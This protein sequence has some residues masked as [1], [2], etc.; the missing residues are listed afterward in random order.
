MVAPLVARESTYDGEWAELV[1]RSAITLKALTYAPTGGPRR[2]AHDVAARMD[3]ERAQLGLPLL[4]AAR[5]D[6]LALRA[7]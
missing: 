6:V 7:R 2:R 4:L 3:R 5:R 1:Q